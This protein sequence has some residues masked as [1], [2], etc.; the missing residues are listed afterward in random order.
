ML[1]YRSNTDGRALLVLVSMAH[2]T[3]TLD[4]IKQTIER[5]PARLAE[6]KGQ[7]LDLIAK[8]TRISPYQREVM[9]RLYP[10]AIP[11]TALKRSGLV[12]LVAP[13]LA[14]ATHIV[15]W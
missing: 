8:A 3:R 13:L 14:L 1:I 9:R 15:I 4:G 10:A 11:V 2:G 12:P 5:D 7:G 6:M